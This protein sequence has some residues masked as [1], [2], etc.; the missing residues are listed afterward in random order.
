M[1][2]NA[3]DSSLIIKEEDIIEEGESLTGLSSVDEIIGNLQKRR[4]NV[5]NGGVNCIPF[6]FPRFRQE[7]P[8]IEQGQ[9]VVL[10]A[11]QKVKSFK[12]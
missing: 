3:N 5:L 9:Y 7:V 4:E 6:P 10:S 2:T 11:N 1:I 8:G 12:I